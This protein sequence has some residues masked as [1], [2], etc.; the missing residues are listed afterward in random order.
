MFTAAIQISQG[1]NCNEFTIADASSYA[2][3]SKG[4]FSSRQLIIYKSDGSIFRGAGQTSDVINFDFATYT[5]DSI[6]IQGLDVDYSFYVLMTLV[7]SNPQVGS[8][9]TA[10]TKFALTCYTMSAFYDRAKKQSIDPRYELNRDYV[11][12]THRLLVEK[13]AAENAASVGDIVS[14]QLALNRARRVIVNNK[15]PY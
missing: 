5:S 2:T 12:D 7:S 14:A 4:S 8:V 9:Y 6:T 11:T 1:A 10:G 15:I 3:E 13:K